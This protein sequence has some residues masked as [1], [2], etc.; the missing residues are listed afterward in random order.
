M[1]ISIIVPVY[2]VEKYLPKCLDSL[3]AQAE[4][5][6][7]IILIND[8]SMDNSLSICQKYANLEPRIRIIDQENKGLSA[9]VRV[10]VAAA[11]CEYVGFVDS[12]DYVESDMYKIMSE[13]MIETGADIAICNHDI[14]NEKGEHSNPIEY[15]GCDKP[16]YVFIRKG[17]KFECP[18]FPTLK[19]KNFIPAYRVNKL[20][21][22]EAIVNNIAFEDKGVRHGED[23][24]LTIPILF[25]SQKIVYVRGAFYHYLQRSDSIVHTYNRGNLKDWHIILEVLKKAANKY[26]YE[27]DDFEDVSLAWLLSLCL[28]KIRIS[29][30]SK[31]NRREEYKFIGEDGEVR[32][33]LGNVKIK[34]NF[35]HK[36]IFS[37]LKKRMY[38]LL[39]WIY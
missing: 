15:M 35:K 12:D 27:I 4:C 5:V 30:L 38:R 29:S 26:N 10:G 39:S 7:E 17:G 33:L 8:G 31:R 3:C 13:K 23:V 36:I 16:Q 22:K 37:L 25:A 32:K 34:T 14:V 11:A 2:N 18:I 6:K 28:F 19:N 21:K 1:E 9:A 20:M 24:A